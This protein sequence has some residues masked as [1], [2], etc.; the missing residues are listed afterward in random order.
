MKSSHQRRDLAESFGSDAVRY[1]RTRPGY[2]S[3]LVDRILV[4]LDTPTVLDVGIGTGLAA[5]PY[6]DAGGQVLG[7]EVDPRMAAVA[8]KAGFAVEVADFEQWDPAGR[9]FD[10]VVAGQAWHWIDPVAGAEKAADVLRPGG[11]LAAFWNVADPG[12]ALADE[13]AEVYRAIDT[14]L[15]FTPW[16]TSV[17]GYRPILDVAEAAVHATGRFTRPQRWHYEWSTFFTRDGWLDQ[18]PTAA[19]H[20]Q[21]PPA[22]LNALLNA[23]GDVIDAHGGSFTMSYITVAFLADQ[24]DSRL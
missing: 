23:L 6:R 1:N 5:R 14:G 8:R 15:P 17:D 24:T 19:G 4:G 3:A 9:L 12:P 7:V 21:L 16:A 22:T 10:L 2:P 20:G 18:V 11:R 13:F